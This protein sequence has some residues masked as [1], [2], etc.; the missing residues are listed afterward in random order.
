[1]DGRSKY[2]TWANSTLLWRQER[3]GGTGTDQGL[4]EAASA[5]EETS[6]RTVCVKNY[7]DYV[8][9]HVTQEQTLQEMKSK[10]QRGPPSCKLQ[11]M[12]LQRQ[13]GPL[14]AG[15]PL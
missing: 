9:N 6:S 8:V 4:W 1:M 7:G 2:K 10:S 15:T 13:D 12:G 5:K 3:P 11:S 14:R